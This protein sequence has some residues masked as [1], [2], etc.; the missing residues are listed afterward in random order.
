MVFAF[1]IQTLDSQEPELVYY[2]F[3][4]T[5]MGDTFS[6]KDSSS[7]DMPNF[8][9]GTS[10]EKKDLLHLIIKRVHMLYSLKLKQS[11]I[12]IQNEENKTVMKGCYLEKNWNSERFSVV[13]Q[14]VP[15][16]GFSL[17]GL[18]NENISHAQNTLDLITSELQKYLQIVSYP[19]VTTKVLDTVALILDCFLPGGQMLFLN[20]S[21]IKS[22]EKQ[23]ELDLQR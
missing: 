21:I 9:Y 16:I 13:W 11:L 12:P 22:L 14:G 17:V 7:Q 15:G 23:L 3:Y 1:I 20:S 10:I 19:A 5:S 8:L 4:S 2:R 18:E 6:T